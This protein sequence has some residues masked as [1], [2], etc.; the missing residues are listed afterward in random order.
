MTNPDLKSLANAIRFLAIDAVEAANSGHPGMPMG[1]AD[2]AT[3]L[4]TEFLNFNAKDP[5]WI[6]RDRFVL[7]AGHGSMLIYA[8]LYLTGY[9]DIN[10]DDIKNFR[11]LHSK[12]AGHPEYGHLAGIETTTGPL[13]QGITNAVGMALSAKMLAARIGENLVN[14]KI[15]CLAGDGCLMEGISQEAISF[16]G[17]LNLDNLVVL[18]DNNSISI[19]G[20][21]SLATNEDMKKRF[22]ACGFEVIS[23]DGHNFDEIRNALSKVK[24]QKKPL[25]ID[26][27]TIIGFGSDAKGGSEKC[28]G[29]P[30]GKDEVAKVREKL[31]WNYAPFEI[32][33]E[34]KKTWEK[35]S[36]KSINSYEGWQVEF[37]KLDADK[38]AEVL[39]IQNKELPKDFAQKLNEFKAE[40][41]ARKS[42]IASRK[43]SQ[44]ALEF[45]TTN[46]PELIGGSADLTGSVLTKTAATNKAINKNDFSGRYIHYGIREHAMGAIMNSLALSGNFIP[47]GGTFLVFSDYMKPAIRLAALMKQQLIYIFTHDSIG[48]GEDGPTHQPIE[49]LAMLRGIPNLNV[50]RP[51]DEEETLACFEIALNSKETPCAIILSRQNLPYIEKASQNYYRGGYV[52]SSSKNPDVVII[53]T[54]SE[55]SAAA[56]AKEILAQKS[57]NARVVSMPCLEIFDKQDEAYK[58]DVLGDNKILR[59]AIEAGISQ[60]FDKYL[61]FNGIFIGMNDF[62]ASAKGED[63]FKYFGITAENLAEKI[64]KKLEK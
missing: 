13:G 22:E 54:G 63:L 48:V 51:C 37:S 46:L 60:S 17:N 10:L 4:F 5:K 55:V 52:V 15:Y 29:S 32:P 64:A 1:C 58:K 20:N 27:K 38:Q 43:S 50:L 49:H 56:K 42:N 6:N 2:I 34:I 61:G 41:I 53:A 24:S 47:Y 12:C 21:T 44:N 7:S 33:S 16:A 57:I 23:I 40:I 11:Q 9:E 62:G 31:N 36:Q 59:V 30:L 28:H 19:D 35:A 3:V 39:R 26:C 25:L 45:L 8:L 14:H 18:W